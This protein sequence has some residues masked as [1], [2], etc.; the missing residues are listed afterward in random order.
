MKSKPVILSGL[1][2]LILLLVISVLTVSKPHQSGTKAQLADASQQCQIDGGF[3]TDQASC[4]GTDKQLV[5]IIGG[6]TGTGGDN[7]SIQV[8]CKNI[9]VILP[10]S[11]EPVITEGPIPTT[12]VN[13]PSLTPTPSVCP[14]PEEPTINISNIQIICPDGCSSQVPQ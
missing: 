5:N 9:T 2:V 6:D 10:P 11:P 12:P 8:C 7:S 14:L 3:V 1:V 13:E 4:S